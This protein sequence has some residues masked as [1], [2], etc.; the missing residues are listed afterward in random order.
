MSYLHIYLV[1]GSLRF[2]VR[3]TSE[4]IVG[5]DEVQSG[6]DEVENIMKNSTARGGTVGEDGGEGFE[7]NEQVK[8]EI[9][10]GSPPHLTTGN[11]GRGEAVKLS[12]HQT[13]EH[14][15]YSA[16]ELSQGAGEAR[17]EVV[18]SS[19]DTPLS[20]RCVWGATAGSVGSVGSV[21]S[22]GSMGSMGS[23][24]SIGAGRSGGSSAT[25]RAISATRSSGEGRRGGEVSRGRGEGRGSGGMVPVP[26]LQAAAELSVV[27]GENVPPP[28]AWAQA[29]PK[30]VSELKLTGARSS[31]GAI[32]GGRIRSPSSAKGAAHRWAARVRSPS[33]NSNSGS[34]TTSSSMDD[35]GN[36]GGSIRSEAE[37]LLQLL[38]EF[39]TTTVF[40]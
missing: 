25:S 16:G 6:Y 7:S 37:R 15:I 9:T 13:S 5:I 4:I 30:A 26:N 32:P 31:G 38:R 29:E 14:Q 8:Y 35:C 33:M 40:D 28:P 2:K 22:L 20:A 19:S 24:G 1:G 10:M 11:D 18:V 39:E 36:N 12:M 27:G 17:R 3:G 21:G 34:P 23:M